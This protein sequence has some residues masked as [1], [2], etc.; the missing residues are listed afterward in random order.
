MIERKR[1]HFSHNFKAC[2][3]QFQKDERRLRIVEPGIVVT[4]YKRIKFSFNVKVKTLELRSIIFPSCCNKIR[5][6]SELREVGA[7]HLK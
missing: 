5:T 7:C 6:L 1:R 4:G 2:M 3:N